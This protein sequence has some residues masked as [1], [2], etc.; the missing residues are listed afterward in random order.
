MGLVYTRSIHAI[1]L[2][3]SP[4]VFGCNGI[5]LLVYDNMCFLLN[6]IGLPHFLQGIDGFSGTSCKLC[7]ICNTYK[8]NIRG[9]HEIYSPDSMTISVMINLLDALRIRISDFNKIDWV[10]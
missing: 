6:V 2:V 9:F 3:G 1:F 10:H 8:V 4:L 5:F 7:K